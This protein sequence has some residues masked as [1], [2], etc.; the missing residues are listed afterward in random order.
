MVSRE[1]LRGELLETHARGQAT[2]KYS[3]GRCESKDG[4]GHTGE[5]W[6]RMGKD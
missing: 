4:G 3:C 1:L 2:A 6:D 5:L